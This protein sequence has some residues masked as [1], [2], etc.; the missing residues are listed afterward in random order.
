MSHARETILTLF[1]FSPE[2]EIV[3]V[4]VHTITLI[5]LDIFW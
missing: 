4:L 2:A 3:L 5:P 1:V